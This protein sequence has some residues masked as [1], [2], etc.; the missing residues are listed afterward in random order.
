MQLS[1]QECRE[2]RDLL[3]SDP[4]DV[5][6]TSTQDIPSSPT[7]LLEAFEALMED[8]IPVSVDN[9]TQAEGSSGTL[10]HLG[11]PRLA[12]LKR[13]SKTFPPPTINKCAHLFLCM[14]TNEISALPKELPMQNLS[15]L[16][17]ESLFQL[18]SMKDI[19]IKEAD[20]DG[21]VVVLDLDHYRQLCL[22][23]VNNKS[24]YIPIDFTL[25]DTYMV[26]FYTLIDRAYND[27]TISKT[28]WDF[29]RTPAPRIPTLYCLPKIH[30]QGYLRGRPIVSGSGSFTEG[31]SEFIDP[32]M[33][34]HVESLF[35]YTKD[36]LSRLQ[37]SG[38]FDGT[39]WLTI[40]FD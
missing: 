16:H 22:D 25:V 7:P 2:L 23:I 19:V 33:R 38:G 3:L 5:L 36:T 10:L 13:K 28:I 6:P 37:D 20:K 39:F 4:V 29:I 8:L 26:E 27:G 21:C 15:P 30:K 24:W 1:L 17:Q 35:S 40:S 32:I 14:V 12:D 11:L 9:S 18:K 34:P 31:A